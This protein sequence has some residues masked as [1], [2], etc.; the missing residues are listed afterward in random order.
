M[1]WNCGALQSEGGGEEGPSYEICGAESRVSNLKGFPFAKIP[2][3]CK[4]QR[5]V[6][7]NPF[8]YPNE[9]WSVMGALCD[10]MCAEGVKGLSERDCLISTCDAFRL[11]EGKTDAFRVGLNGRKELDRYPDA[12][13]AALRGRRLY[14]RP[15][16]GKKRLF[17]LAIWGKCPECDGV[18]A[19][20]KPRYWVCNTCKGRGEI[21]TGEAVP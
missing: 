7:V 12:I 9:P 10:D 2:R 20:T 6:I 8:S 18:G 11:I 13:L 5:L 4:R 16:R 1:C 3:Y 14:F 19:T 21:V 17:R 15:K